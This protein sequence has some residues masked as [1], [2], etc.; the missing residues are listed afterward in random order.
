MNIA[1]RLRLGQAVAEACIDEANY[2]P[3]IIDDMLKRLGQA[4]GAALL[5]AQ[6]LDIP[7]ASCTIEEE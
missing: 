7:V 2:A 1:L 4:L 5:T 3:D 6:A